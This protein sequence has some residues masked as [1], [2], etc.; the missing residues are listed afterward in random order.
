MVDMS[1]VVLNYNTYE[2]TS[3]CLSSVFKYPPKA[4]FKLLLVDNA[5]TDGSFEKLKTKFK[6]IQVIENDKNYGFAKGN[7]DGIQRVYKNS[8][9]VLLLNSDTIVRAGAIDR[10]FNYAIK[11]HSD[12]TSCKLVYKNGKFQA[13][14][15]KLPYFFPVFVWISGIDDVLAKFVRLPSYQAK[16]QK[17]LGQAQWVS[18]SVMLVASRVFSKIGFF[19]EKIFMYGEDVDF[20]LRASRAGFKTGWTNDSEIVH[21]GGASSKISPQYTQW[22]GEFRGLLYLY[23]KHFGLVQSVLLKLLMYL[24]IFLRMVAFA[25]IGKFGYSKQY[26]KIITRV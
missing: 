3:T 19:D 13:N 20:C 9:Y 5:S 1:I 6:N 12:I 23:K 14:G 8:R 26:A 24:F 22:L 11:A 16:T 4:S 2:E 15:G 10:L 25:V 21:L 18:G 7:N 17:E